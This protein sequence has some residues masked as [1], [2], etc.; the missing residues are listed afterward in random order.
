MFLEID[1]RRHR[2]DVLKSRIEL[3]PPTELRMEPLYILSPTVL[4]VPM[5]WPNK[6][7]DLL[8]MRLKPWLNTWPRPGVDAF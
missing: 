7:L 6:T 3:L 8:S 1:V 2:P 5:D 4:S